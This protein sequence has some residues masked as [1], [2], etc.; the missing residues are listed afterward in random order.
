MQS[1]NHSPTKNNSLH[2]LKLLKWFCPD[3]LYEEIEGDLIQKFNRDLKVSDT[4]KVSDTYRLR[5]AKCRLMW[6]VIRV[7]PEGVTYQ[8]RVKPCVD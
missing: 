7:S 3:H 1:D 2:S 4:S 8:H 5:R 6:N